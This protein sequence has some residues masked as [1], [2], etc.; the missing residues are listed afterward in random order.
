MKADMNNPTV[1]PIIL[2]VYNRPRHT[3]Q[4]I[5][6]LQKNELAEVSELFIFSDAPKNESTA[7]NV[8]KVRT[9]IRTIRGFKKITIIERETNLGLA[10]SII[11]GVT[12]IVNKYGRVIVLE[13][14]LI[15]SPYFLRFMNDAL[16]FY[17]E[18]KKVMH[19]AG[20]MIP[21]DTTDL[22]DTF[23]LKPTTCWG[24][25][26]WKRAWNYFEKN[27][28][29]LVNIFTKDM[30]KD[31]N[32]DNSTDYFSHIILNKK[33]KINTWAIYWY[34]SVFLAGGL[35]LHPKISFV[36]NIGN[37]CSGTHRGDSIAFD[38]KLADEYPVSFEEKTEVSMVA[39]DAL[40]QWYLASREP[41]WKKLI[42][43][44]LKNS[45]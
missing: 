21:I 44:V 30:I 45:G 12:E 37:D 19:I 9:Y 17:K 20:Y 7:D 38:V 33:G 26:T 31:F 29:H 24:W 28:D 4:T 3:Q 15:T 5:E 39:G 18:E 35:S 2:F 10:D 34:A 13:D 22:P 25:A 6:A 1:S 40:R 41:Y 23:F 42:P 32:I 11:Q 36:K 43:S 27:T 14:D 8:K 16:E